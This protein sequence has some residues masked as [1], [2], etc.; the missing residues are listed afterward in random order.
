VTTNVSHIVAT[1]TVAAVL[2]T[3]CARP[4]D[5]PPGDSKAPDVP[6]VLDVLYRANCAGCHGVDAQGGA[7][8]GLADPV[9]LRIADEATVRQVMAVGVPRTAMPA[10]AKT[11][12]GT[13]TDAQLDVIVGSMRARRSRVA[14]VSGLNP[15]PYSA[16]AA[17][18]PARG[19]ETFATFCARC[20]GADGRGG[21]GGSSIVD[22]SYL[23]L[24]SDQG[25]RTTVI[26]GRPDLGA[27]DWRG[28]V[29][30]RPMSSEEVSDVVAWLSAHRG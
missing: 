14:D 25:L 16:P 30:G 10:F 29:P 13:L 21:P 27:P 12:G 15:P 22:P 23:S 11:A 18:D 7:A 2:T 5:R 8:R 19:R 20:H 17:G 4:L 26:A 1:L 6:D 28:N 3:G 24:V 9:F